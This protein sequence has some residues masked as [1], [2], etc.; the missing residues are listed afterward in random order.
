M[1]ERS[2]TTK[3]T[4]K[5][6]KQRRKIKP[7]TQKETTIYRAPRWLVA[8]RFASFQGVGYAF[9]SFLFAAEGDEGFALEV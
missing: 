8:E 6:E 4:E 1:E 5:T 3:G 2:F 7:R 9:L